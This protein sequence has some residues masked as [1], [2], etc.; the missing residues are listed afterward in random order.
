MK[1]W[2]T[3]SIE[4]RPSAETSASQQLP[5][6]VS[7][8]VSALVNKTNPVHNFSCIFIYILCMFRATMC[9]SSGET[10]VSKRHL[11]FVTL[12]GWL[13][14]MHPF[15]TCFGRLCVHHQELI[16][17]SMRHLVFVTLCGWLSGMHPFSTC[18]GRLCSHHQEKQLYLCDTWYLSLCVDDCLVCTLSLQVSGDYV[19][20][21]RRNNCIYATLGICHS[22]WMTVWYA[23][24]LYRFRATMCPSSGETTVSMRHLVFV[25]LCGWLS[26]MH[27]FSTCFGRLWA[28]HQELISVPIRHLLFVTLCGWLSGMHTRESST[29]TEWQIPGV[30][31]WYNY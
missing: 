9:P 22:V 1:K 11:V 14:G 8:T 31:Y 20:I 13:S 21:I 4:Q 16:T 12:C 15:S 17:V 24:F 23:P 28:H 25:T 27:P 2:P 18:F 10:T 29:D 19:P 30:A 26:G 7:R 3:D 5:P 6:S